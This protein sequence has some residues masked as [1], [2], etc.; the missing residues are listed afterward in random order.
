M[1]T[2]N[3]DNLKNLTWLACESLGS[4]FDLGVALLTLCSF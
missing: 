4:E 1:V 3:T 2:L